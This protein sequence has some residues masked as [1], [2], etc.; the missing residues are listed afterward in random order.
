MTSRRLCPHDFTQRAPVVLSPFHASTSL[1]DLCICPVLWFPVSACPRAPYFRPRLA[2]SP[3]LLA[4]RHPPPRDHH[5]RAIFTAATLWCLLP[6]LVLAAVAAVFVTPSPPRCLVPMPHTDVSCRPCL[7]AARACPPLRDF[8]PPPRFPA[9]SAP[10]RRRR[11]VLPP[12]PHRRDRRDLRVSRR[13]DP[14]SHR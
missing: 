5:R 13:R 6:V 11:R 9:A 10:S 14:S 4:A 1:S 3:P 12:P 8:P 7:P 2:P